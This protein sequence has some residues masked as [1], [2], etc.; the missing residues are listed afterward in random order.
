MSHRTMF[1][2]FF[3]GFMAAFGFIADPETTKGAHEIDTYWDRAGS[4]I[5]DAYRD[6]TTQKKQQK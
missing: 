2:Y 1:E 5:Q 6:E 4:Y 3:Q